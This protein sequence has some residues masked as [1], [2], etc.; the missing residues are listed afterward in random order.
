MPILPLFSGMLKPF[1]LLKNPGKPAVP[2][3]PPLHPPPSPPHTPVTVCSSA[4]ST[5]PLAYNIWDIDGTTRL[6]LHPTPP[7]HPTCF[8][9]SLKLAVGQG[10]GPL[11]PTQPCFSLKHSELIDSI[12][13]KNSKLQTECLSQGSRIMGVCSN[14]A[15]PDPLQPT[16]TSNEADTD[17]EDAAKPSSTWPSPIS[18][19]GVGAA[20]HSCHGCKPV[21]ILSAQIH[22]LRQVSSCQTHQAGKYSNMASQNRPPQ[23]VTAHTVHS[24]TCDVVVNTCQGG[25]HTLQWFFKWQAALRGAPLQ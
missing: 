13:Q 1:N 23:A 9:L 18:M 8:I 15:M 5:D 25:W 21:Y 3:P 17:S 7:T 2:C 19:C 20:V 16:A 6:L 11:N 24:C 22:C 12:T 4:S 14:Q 10:L